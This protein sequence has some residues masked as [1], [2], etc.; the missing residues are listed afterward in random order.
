MGCFEGANR[1]TCVPPGDSTEA[2]T[3][4]DATKTP[5]PSPTTKPTP[6]ACTACD[7]RESSW[8]IR[9]GL[10][11]AAATAQIEKNCNKKDKWVNKGFCRLSC[12]KAGNGYPGDVCCDE[13]LTTESPSESPSDHATDL[14]SIRSSDL[15]SCT[16]CDDIETSWQVK[17]GFD[18]TSDTYRINNYC[19]K[20]ERWIEKGFCRLS[21]YKAGNGYP[22]DVCCD[23]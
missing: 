1:A 14:S 10:S 2:P 16:I 11:C 3:P 13:S 22:G 5:T 17:N 19:N 12:Y 23:E 21:C 7:D 20:D 4:D 15:S 6:T 8:M 9:N 18:C